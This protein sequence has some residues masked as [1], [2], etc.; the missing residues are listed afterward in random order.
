MNRPQVSS[1]VQRRT[2]PGRRRGNG[3]WTHR[4]YSDDSRLRWAGAVWRWLSDDQR[5]L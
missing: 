4:A 3:S 1:D 2:G 5:I